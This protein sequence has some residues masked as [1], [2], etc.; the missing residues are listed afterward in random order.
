MTDVQVTSDIGW[1]KGNAER[2]LWQWF[3]VGLVPGL[4]EAFGVPPVVVSRLD[5][6]WVIAGCWEITRD[7]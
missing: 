7:I 3:A 1:G 5:L 6:N 4:E 2:A